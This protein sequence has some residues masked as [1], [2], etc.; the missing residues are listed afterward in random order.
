[1]NLKRTGSISAAAA[2]LFTSLVGCSQDEPQNRANGGS[3]N[4]VQDS[5]GTRDGQYTETNVKACEGYTPNPD[6]TKFF[7]NAIWGSFS[8]YGDC[9]EHMQGNLLMD[10]AAEASNAGPNSPRYELRVL[11]Y[12]YGGKEDGSHEVSIS[13]VQVGDVKGKVFAISEVAVNDDGEFSKWLESERGKYEGISRT[14]EEYWQ[15][16]FGASVTFEE[17]YL[18]AEHFGD[19]FEI[20]PVFDTEDSDQMDSFG[21]CFYFAFDKAKIPDG[22]RVLKY[23]LTVD[24][25]TQTFAFEL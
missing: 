23:D 21:R 16:A 1:M 7:P 2:L 5:S 24:G 9:Q 8:Q 17:A 18:S 6:L 3:T 25:E 14:H 4:K 22:A 19:T 15:K 10:L 12:G 11:S 20:G 13:E